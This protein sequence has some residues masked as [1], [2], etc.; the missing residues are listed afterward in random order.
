[1][2]RIPYL[3]AWLLSLC[4]AAGACTEPAEPQFSDVTGV[5]RLQLTQ[6]PTQVIVDPRSSAAVTVKSGVLELNPVWRF[7]IS[8]EQE[9]AQGPGATG[10][11]ERTDNG[12][13]LN[14]TSGISEPAVID[15]EVLTVTTGYGSVLV[16]Q[17]VGS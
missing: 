3:R 4:V 6:T 5:Y 14:Y 2:R 16:F 15:G 13:I 7:Q 10:T 11:Y 1:M 8:Y 9:N 12:V 17:K